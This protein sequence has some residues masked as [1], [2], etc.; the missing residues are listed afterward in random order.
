MAEPKDPRFD[1]YAPR[2][3]VEGSTQ[4][5][6]TQG[7]ALR[8]ELDRR[9]ES[10]AEVYEWHVTKLPEDQVLSMARVRDIVV[11]LYSDAQESYAMEERR[12]W[13][14]DDHRRALVE[15][16]PT[17]D[18]FTQTHPRI[19]L[20]ITD[21]DVT[22]EKRAHIMNLISLKAEHKASNKTLERQQQEV[23]SYFKHHFTR[24]AKPGEAE[25]AEA[26]GTGHKAT[27][28]KLPAPDAYQKK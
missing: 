6:L 21:P 26:K 22:P 7:S 25:E 9:G 4:H 11:S 20:A 8:R 13:Q 5:Q 18:H 12:D 10:N 2:Q 27:M 1:P 14:A 3:H 19:F 23:S 28:V 17:Y 16:N 15:D 24:E